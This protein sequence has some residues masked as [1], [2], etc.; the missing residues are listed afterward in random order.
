MVEKD[1]HRVSPQT[2]QLV[3]FNITAVPHPTRQLPLVWCGCLLLCVGLANPHHGEETELSQYHK[4][5]PL[6][7][8][9]QSPSFP[10][11]LTPCSVNLVPI[12]T[13]SF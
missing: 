3:T 6:A 12:S 13:V 9:S 7:S 1:P 8:P 10:R 2:T 4:G 11:P 5:L